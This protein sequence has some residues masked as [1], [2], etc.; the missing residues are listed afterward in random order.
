MALITPEGRTIPSTV[1]YPPHFTIHPEVNPSP[2]QPSLAQPSSAQLSP[3]QPSP[4]INW[5][6]K[7]KEAMTTPEYSHPASTAY[8][9]PST[10]QPSGAALANGSTVEQSGLYQEVYNKV[11]ADIMSKNQ[12]L[13]KEIVDLKAQN[14]QLAL[15]GNLNQSPKRSAEEALA[16]FFGYNKEKE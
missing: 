7:I 13:Q 8:A 14:M 9:Q 16:D 4:A 15:I 2:V 10:A 12:N 6:E 1:E 11:M 3:A 5:S